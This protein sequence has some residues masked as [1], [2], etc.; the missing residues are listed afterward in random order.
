MLWRRLKNRD[1]SE[2]SLINVSF[3]CPL[4]MAIRLEV[5]RPLLGT[6]NSISA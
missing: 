1:D 2:R 6:P 4:T 5:S 3:G